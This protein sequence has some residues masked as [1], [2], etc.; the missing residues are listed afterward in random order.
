MP[1]K[2]KVVLKT[3][4]R[5]DRRRE[6]P[7]NSVTAIPAVRFTVCETSSCT[8]RVIVNVEFECTLDGITVSCFKISVKQILQ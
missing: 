6:H 5:V 8:R 4:D 2:L 1:E 7:A 3:S